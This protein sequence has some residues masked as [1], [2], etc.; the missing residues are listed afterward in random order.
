MKIELVDIALDTG[1][2]SVMKN[3]YLGNVSNQWQCLE[4]ENSDNL[5]LYRDYH[6][7]LWLWIITGVV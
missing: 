7:R 5:L 4:S 6:S 1:L 2:R 3:V